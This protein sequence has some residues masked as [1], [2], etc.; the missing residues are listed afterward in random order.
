MIIA[1][2][3]PEYKSPWS[4]V[5][6]YK[7]I[8]LPT[9]SPNSSAKIARNILGGLLLEPS[10][11]EKIVEKTGGNP[12]F[13]EEM[14]REFI[15]RG[16]II[17]DGNL[18]IT[19]RSIDELAIPSTV[20]G[21]LAAKIDRLNEDLKQTI[22]VASVIGRDFLFRILKRIM[23]IEQGLRENLCK[24]VEFEILYEKTLY[25]E[26]EYIFTHALTQK[27]AYESLLIQR[28]KIIHEKIAVTI[29]NLYEQKLEEYYE[30]L[31][32][33]YEKSG[34]SDKT[35]HYSVLAGEK[36]MSNGANQLAYEFFHKALTI[37]QEEFLEVDPEIEFKIHFN[38]GMASHNAG[39]FEEGISEMREAHRIS[40]QQDMI[41]NE[42]QC[43]YFQGLFLIPFPD[44]YDIE[45]YC[46][47]NIIKIY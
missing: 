40:R 30:V 6:Q 38:L 29:E 22:Q 7:K 4:Q 37:T 18:F 44:T 15:D 43:L 10:L 41:E 33:H 20:Q 47:K 9:L 11:E 28:R 8:I 13:I 45:K 26:L 2:Y 35:L 5:H 36:T 25:P 21:I 3:R 12:F 17:K 14:V 34:N 23:S 32:Y 46:D 31:S 1:N 42:K 27:V 24:L 19:K 16:D 39:G